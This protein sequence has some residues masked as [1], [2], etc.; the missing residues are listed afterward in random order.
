MKPVW[1]LIDHGPSP[2][3]WNLAV[4]EALLAS[5][6]EDLGPPTLRF[7]QWSAPTLSLGA[8]QKWPDHRLEVSC[9]ESGLDVVR[10]PT[11]GRAVIHG[12]DLTYSLVAG[13]RNGFPVSTTQ[14]Y[15]R[16]GQGLKTGLKR[17]GIVA[18]AGA[19]CRL[20]TAFACFAL[21]TPADLTWQGQKFIG[22]AQ[23]WRGQSFLQHGSIIMESQEQIWLGLLS[24]CQSQSSRPMLITSIAEILKFPITLATL[25]TALVQGFQEALGVT[26]QAGELSRPE[27]IWAE[28]RRTHLRL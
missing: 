23:V 16:L 26:F 13:T 3:D 4:D 14:V 18:E 28:S 5:H 22:S 17:L 20:G 7:Y 11:G 15:R 24:N 12:G 10:R 19:A 6:V 27:A 21:A 2:A 1:R 25:K 9:R 8:G